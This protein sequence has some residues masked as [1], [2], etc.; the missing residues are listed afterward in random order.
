MRL[1]GPTPSAASPSS[2]AP[3]MPLEIV[4]GQMSLSLLCPNWHLAVLGSSLSTATPASTPAST[5]APPPSYTHAGSGSLLAMP[6][7]S[8]TA[9][10]RSGSAKGPDYLYHGAKRLPGQPWSQVQEAA[11]R[12]DKRATLDEANGGPLARRSDHNESVRRDR[13]ASEAARAVYLKHH[14]DKLRPFI[15]PQVG[16]PVFE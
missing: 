9:P 3:L 16:P 13:D 4:P 6:G 14:L 2:H 5:P 1:D 15:A 11:A 12:K 7:V 10:A 8:L